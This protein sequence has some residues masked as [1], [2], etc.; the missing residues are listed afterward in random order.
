METEGGRF[1]LILS[2]SIIFLPICFAVFWV[3]LLITVMSLGYLSYR[4][5]EIL[6]PEPSKK[7]LEVDDYQLHVAP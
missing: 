4:F 1:C 3:L 7:Y 5:K 2:L 6:G